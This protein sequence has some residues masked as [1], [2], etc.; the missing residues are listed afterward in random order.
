MKNFIYITFFLSLILLKPISQLSW[1]IWY[2]VNQDYVAEELCEN[3]DK[4]ELECNGK[5]YLMK[6]LEKAENNTSSKD[7]KDKTVNPF[8]LKIE[9]LQNSEEVK[10][11]VIPVFASE[12]KVLF[13]YI[14]H[15]RKEFS[16]KIFH[17]PTNCT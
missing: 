2:Q 14:D 17:P 12:K 3:Q 11:K 13:S 16:S 1:E 8:S 4:P 5:C 15:Y 10:I 7:D 9:L 6:Q